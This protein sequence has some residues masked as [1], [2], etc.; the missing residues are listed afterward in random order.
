MPWPSIG[1]KDVPVVFIDLKEFGLWLIMKIQMVA[2]HMSTAY[3]NPLT[4][5]FGSLK[6]RV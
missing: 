1:F 3:G 6:A 5:I 4:G 2:G